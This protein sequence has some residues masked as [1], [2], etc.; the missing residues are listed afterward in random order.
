MV[1]SLNIHRAKLKTQQG[2]RRSG[3]Y[4]GCPRI[5]LSMNFLTYEIQLAYQNI[6]CDLSR[7]PSFSDYG[8]NELVRGHVVRGSHTF[9]AFNKRLKELKK[10]PSSSE[11]RNSA[12]AI[13][14][15]SKLVYVQH[16]LDYS[17]FK[18]RTLSGSVMVSSYIHLQTTALITITTHF[19]IA[20]FGK[21]QCFPPANCSSSQTR[22]L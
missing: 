3:G 20:C 1:R 13:A 21:G 11:K 19:T 15:H 16:F 5:Y 4:Y 7:N 22:Q 18:T 12:Q 8:H 2:V 17:C 10:K 9:H 14:K 6:P